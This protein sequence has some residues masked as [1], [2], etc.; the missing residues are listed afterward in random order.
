M[1]TATHVLHWD[2]KLPHK[3]ELSVAVILW[4]LHIGQAGPD[5]SHSARDVVEEL[6]DVGVFSATF[7]VTDKMSLSGAR[8]TR[9]ERIKVRDNVI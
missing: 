4:S 2:L 9:E 7:A 3:C 1:E 6:N 5:W 8:D